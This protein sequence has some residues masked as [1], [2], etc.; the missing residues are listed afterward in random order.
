MEYNRAFQT[1]VTDVVRY[2]K[3]KPLIE[4]NPL[5]INHF[6]I[7][8][9]MPEVYAHRF[10]CEYDHLVA[11]KGDLSHG[12]KSSQTQKE[13]YKAFMKAKK[14]C[15]EITE[16]DMVRNIILY[17]KRFAPDD[18]KYDIQ[19]KSNE[20][21]HLD[22]IMDEDVTKEERDAA[23]LE[24]RKEILKLRYKNEEISYL[25]YEK[26]LYTLEDRKWFNYQIKLDE[27]DDR[28]SSFELQVDYND[29]FVRWLE[30]NNITLQG[31]EHEDVDPNSEEY[32]ELLVEKW[33]KS[34][35]MSL[36]ATMLVDDGGET[37]RSVVAN[38]PEGTVVQHL[39]IDRDNLEDYYGD[40]LS[41]EEIRDIAN[42]TRNR[43][44]YK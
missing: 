30:S 35:L 36:A 12:A 18:L 24:L 43:R 3:N 27:E 26:S 25:D 21:N 13:T 8:C 28:P 16:Y 14:D 22:V 41:A 1:T 23:E 10:Q 39:E 11:S 42:K 40:T 20:L 2:N 31:T 37:F 38:E 34:A 32:V 33:A 9:G 15:N 29:Q 4:L 5:S 7:S 44:I 6:L 19:L 17:E